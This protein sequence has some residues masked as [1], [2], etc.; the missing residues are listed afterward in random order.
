MRKIKQTIAYRVPSWN[1]CNLDGSGKIGKET[2]RFCVKTKL[3]YICTLYDTPLSSEDYKVNKYYD[4][5]RATA[6]YRISI[7]E[8]VSTVPT[9]D[10]KLIVQE[11]IKQYKKQV[12]DLLNQNYPRSIAEA[13]V[14][15]HMLEDK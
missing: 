8:P 12:N 7:D 9:I 2:C 5:V 13:I 15:K 6:G 14:I 3:G 4:C 11:A 1:F 10:P